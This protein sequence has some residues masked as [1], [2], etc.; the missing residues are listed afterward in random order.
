MTY[1][2]YHLKWWC[3]RCKKWRLTMMEV[4]DAEDNDDTDP[5]D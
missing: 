4:L 3:P 2:R 1:N 5:E